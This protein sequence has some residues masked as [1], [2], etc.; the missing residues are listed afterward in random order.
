MC[1]DSSHSESDPTVPQS[2]VVDLRKQIYLSDNDCEFGFAKCLENCKLSRHNA[3][4]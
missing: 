4:F 1:S 3:M 2:E